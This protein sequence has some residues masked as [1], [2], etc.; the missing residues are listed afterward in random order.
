MNDPIVEE[1]RKVR[2]EHAKLFNYNLDAICADLQSKH[3]FFVEILS[4]L[5]EA[6]IKK[7]LNHRKL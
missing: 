2:N 1:V 4:N 3:K 5:K 6:T 7:P